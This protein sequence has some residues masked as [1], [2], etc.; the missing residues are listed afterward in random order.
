MQIYI[1]SSRHPPYKEV[2][3]RNVRAMYLEG[4]E[5]HAPNEWEGWCL[6]MSLNMWMLSRWVGPELVEKPV[7]IVYSQICPRLFGD[8]ICQFWP[9]SSPVWCKGL[10]ILLLGIQDGGNACIIQSWMRDVLSSNLMVTLTSSFSRYYKL[11]QEQG[12]WFYSMC[13]QTG[14]KECTLA[15]Q[16]HPDS[17]I[18]LHLTLR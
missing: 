1:V 8:I 17:D 6:V 4:I 12:L 18:T 2:W 11:Q 13:N 7:L 5:I 10:M 15:S 14:I 3:M 16:G 9:Q